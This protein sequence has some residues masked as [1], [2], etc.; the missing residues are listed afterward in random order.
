MDMTDELKAKID[1]KSYRELL[2]QWRNA[3]LGAEPFQ[4]ESGEYW[5]KRMAELRAEPDGDDRH[6]KASKSIGWGG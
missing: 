3:P 5:G 6:V 2:E 4:G 1:A